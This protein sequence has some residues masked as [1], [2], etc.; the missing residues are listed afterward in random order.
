MKA[1]ELLKISNLMSIFRILVIP[2]L[3]VFLAKPDLE[4]TLIALLIVIL[5][6]IS[7]GLDGML[8]RM[9][10]EVSQLG[11]ILDPLADKVFVGALVILLV[12][13]RD[14]PTWL[15][16]LILG[17]DLLILIV[18]ALL[19][20]GQKVIVPPNLTGKYAFVSIAVLLSC[21]VARFEFGVE[22]MGY[23]STALIVASVFN[24]ARVLKFVKRGETPPEFTDKPIY[25]YLRLT[26]L[27]IVILVLVI[28]LFE[29]L[30]A[31]INYMA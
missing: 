22:L 11:M 5:A 7:D 23:I 17:R 28:E 2:F 25:K 16:A 15:A 26:V 3:W 14:F 6:A 12:I 18:A 9:R 27:A 8:A 21:S 1:A 10:N 19:L 29:F 31:S 24:Y 30:M 13:Y 4:S 20:K